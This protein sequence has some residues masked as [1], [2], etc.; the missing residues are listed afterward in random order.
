MVDLTQQS[1]NIEWIY[2][3]LASPKPPAQPQPE[4]VY[5]VSVRGSTQ[6][7]APVRS[8]RQ[9]VVIIRAP[10]RLFAAELRTKVPTRNGLRSDGTIC[11]RKTWI[12]IHRA[13]G[14][15][16]KKSEMT[17][18]TGAGWAGPS[19]VTAQYETLRRAALGQAEPAWSGL[20]HRGGTTRA[21]ATDDVKTPAVILSRRCSAT[22]KRSRAC[23]A[24]L[25]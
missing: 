14:R 25:D 12:E 7:T 1:L 18:N 20:E 8:Q 23:R 6:L 21:K 13:C 3:D 24:R 16:K 2:R 17:S 19:S 11:P 22:Q 5:K 4:C 10:L 9:N 15:R